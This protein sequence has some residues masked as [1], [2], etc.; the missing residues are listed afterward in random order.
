MPKKFD[1]ISPGV[2]ITEIDQ[3]KLQPPARDDGLLVIGR[4]NGGPGLKPVRVRSLENFIEIFGKPV[5]GKGSINTDVWREGN[6]Q[7]PTYAMYAAQAWLASE[8]SPVTFVRLLG[9][10]SP[11]KAA[12]AIQAGWNLGGKNIA[13]PASNT[14]AYG[15]FLFQSASMH[16]LGAGADAGIDVGTEFGVWAQQPIG[17]LAAII[18]A[19]G[20]ALGLNG[21]L[22]KGTP[23][24]NGD[25]SQLTTSSAGHMIASN[26]SAGQPA[27]FTMK[28]ATGTTSEGAISVPSTGFTFHFDSTQRDGYIRNVLNTNPQRLLA[29][30][31]GS[32]NVQKFFLGETFEESVKRHIIDVSGS[33]GQQLGILMALQSGSTN[34]VDHLA[35]AKYAKTGYFINRDPDP[36]NDKANYQARDMPKLFRLCALSEGEWFQNNYYVTI[37]NLTLGTQANPNSSFS[38]SIRA[39]NGLAVETFSNCNLDESSANFVGKKVGDMYQVWDDNNDRYEMFGLYPNQ[40]NYV[41]VE[42]APD[43]KNNAVN[44]TYMLPFGFEG[45]VTIKNFS[46]ASGSN[47]ANEITAYQSSTAITNA[48][49]TK[50]SFSS[51]FAPAVGGAGLPECFSGSIKMPR[52]ALTEQSTKDNGS[53]YDATD[54]F[55]LNHKLSNKKEDSPLG[56]PS[57]IDLLRYPGGG[58][59]PHAESGAAAGGTEFSF[60]FTLDEIVK[61]SGKY[62]W[63][64]GSMAAGTSRTSTTSTQTLLGEKV[65]QFAAPFFGGFDGVDIKM[66]EPFS[67]TAVLSANDELTHYANYSVKKAIDSVSDREVVNYDVI[68]M[69]GLTATA[70]SNHL[71]NTVENR[72]DALA[73][74]DLDD[75]FKE[76]YEN[77]G[78][79]HAVTD[80]TLS[81]VLATARTRDLNTSYAATYYPRIRL[82]DTITGQNDVIIAPASVGAVGAL[83]FSDAN[84]NGPWFAP[85]G[86]NR[87]G[88][89]ILG[90]NQGPRV[91]G[92]LKNL[93]KAD[94]DDLYELN[95][96]P[97]A[98]F[99]AI[100]EVVIFGQKTLQQTPSALDRINVRRLMIFLKKRIGRIADTILFEGNIESTWSRFRSRASLI[101]EDVQSRFGIEEFK[102]ILDRTITTPDLVDQNIMYAKIFVK[103]TR[104]IEFIAIDFIITKSGV[105]F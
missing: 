94:R 45:P 83:A 100:G 91:V 80:N 5:S 70:L 31:V 17:T 64:S 89:S 73:I 38:L 57:Y 10:N 66:I 24:Q 99:P 77:D 18:Y 14:T 41:R 90:G 54:Y 32:S 33:A 82:R 12:S 15:L 101:L 76:R 63:S 9:E 58:I 34:Y 29:Q 39:R 47:G 11:N 104:S 25:M 43:W 95:I 86:F 52:L 68:S 81:T 69:P 98:R 62:Y 85:A 50:P 55:G 26:A 1:F 79:D 7:G 87:G 61:S 49:F 67:S 20:S 102:L 53:N 105:Q 19:S 16:D 65:K 48:W 3:S 13:T 23:D 78:V 93:S 97:I 92:T 21:N 88:I 28:V 103:P 37:E 72:K 56:H 35:E 4:A 42:M 59:D 40:S 8:T 71:I 22:I 36:T 30:N 75:G 60:I 84:S 51:A 96:N 27:T 6:Q 74:I 44:D 2:Q 46:I